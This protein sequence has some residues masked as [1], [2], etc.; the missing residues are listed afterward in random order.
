MYIWKKP[1]VNLVRFFKIGNLL[2]KA[3]KKLKISVFTSWLSILKRNLIFLAQLCKYC[4]IMCSYSCSVPINLFPILLYYKH[5]NSLTDGNINGKVPYSYLA[6]DNALEKLTK[7]K[8]SVSAIC[9]I[10]IWNF[11][12]N[13]F[14]GS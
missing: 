4:T 14:N 13:L 2:V 6:A 1:F 9:Q 12:R 10:A 8:T 5:N 3:K 7:S 11:T